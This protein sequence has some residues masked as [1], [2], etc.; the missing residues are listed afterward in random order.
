MRKVVAFS[1]VAEFGTGLA[2]LIVPAA[3]VALLLGAETS[4]SR[5]SSAAA[6]VALARWIGMLAGTGSN[7]A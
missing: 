1:S 6:L 2:L 5:R 7:S 3:V 4:E